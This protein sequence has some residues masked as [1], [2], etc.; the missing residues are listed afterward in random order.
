MKRTNPIALLGLTPFGF[1]AGFFADWAFVVRGFSAIR[2]PWSL[3]ITTIVLTGI[4]IALGARVRWATQ[5]KPGRRIDATLAIQI[6]TLAK[7]SSVGGSL[8]FGGVAGILVYTL[9]R[10]VVS[11]ELVPGAVGG[12]IASLVLIIGALI[13][14]RL[15]RIPPDG[16]EGEP[17]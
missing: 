8:I 4:V 17:A 13:A 9:T 10:P 1:A 3:V 16:T 14:E 5:P 7:A 12:L 6:L 2:V 15:C 11:T